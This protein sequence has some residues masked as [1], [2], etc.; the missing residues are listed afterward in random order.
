VCL[1]TVEPAR[2]RRSRARKDWV[3]VH[4]GLPK[5]TSGYPSRSIRAVVAGRPHGSVCSSSMARSVGQ[6]AGGLVERPP[7]TGR[8]SFGSSMQDRLR[9]NGLPPAAL[10][11]SARPE[12]RSRSASI[13]GC[14]P[15]R[16]SAMLV[17][18]Q[19]EGGG[20]VGFRAELLT[21]DM[22]TL[23]T[24]VLPAVRGWAGG[25]CR[26]PVLGSSGGV[27]EFPR[28]RGRAF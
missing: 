10:D 5:G 26:R 20:P 11:R 17:R 1:S 19:R 12:R 8:A 18:R 28:R 9:R 27:T 3:A 13:I 24:R 14:G 7:E 23:H 16:I 21:V 2:P 22:D 6:A 25:C 4:C 15:R